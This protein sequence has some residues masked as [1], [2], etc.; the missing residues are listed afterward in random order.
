[1]ANPFMFGATAT[2]TTEAQALPRYTEYA[3]DFEN[4]KFIFED[5]RHKIVYDNDAMKIWVYKTLKTERDRYLA[6][7]SYYGLELEQ[8]IGQ[9]N[10]ASVHTK[11]E[12]YIRE[13]LLV[14]PYILSIDQITYTSD[15]DLIVITVN[16]TSVYGSF[17]VTA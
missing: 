16:L 5:G 13:G 8:F 2:A 11:L 12:G 3:W 1:M 7:D 4:D 9:G 14:N 17:S 6:Y 15:M 10:R